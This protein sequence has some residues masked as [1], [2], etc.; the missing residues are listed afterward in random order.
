LYCG[1]I[2]IIASITVIIFVGFLLPFINQS[3]GDKI[4]YTPYRISSTYYIT[5]AAAAIEIA[6]KIVLYLR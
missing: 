2:K 6:L 1:T 4:L 3:C 5:A